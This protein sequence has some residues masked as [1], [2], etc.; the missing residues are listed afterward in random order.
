MAIQ[1]LGFSKLQYERISNKQ[2]IDE[3]FQDICIITYDE[4]LQSYKVK[5]CDSR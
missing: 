5:F 2:V 1:K 4:K 3:M